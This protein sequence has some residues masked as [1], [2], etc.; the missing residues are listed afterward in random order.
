MV[1]GA[2]SGVGRAIATRFMT[3]GVS[4]CLVGRRSQDLDMTAK[5]GEAARAG[6]GFVF[7]AD[8]SRDV[9]LESLTSAFSQQLG[10]LD[11]LVHSAGVIA[12]GVTESQAVEDFDRQYA[13]N[14]RGPY[15]LTQLMLPWL[16]RQGG[17]V[18][19]INSTQGQRAVAGFGQ[20]AA[21][22]HA[23]RAVAD[24]VREEVNGQR[25][26][27]LS[28]FL[29]RTATPMQER[30]H[31]LNGTTYRPEYLIQPEDVADVVVHT[32]GLPRTAE[33]TDI[34]IRPLAKPEP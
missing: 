11:V 29:G 22:K 28:V 3:L 32:I 2:G 34:V 10:R 5:Q 31:R 16:K 7:E 6:R 25:V 27:V 14:V 8:I 15:R 12:P 26:R 17:D 21:T 23:L 4:V 20:Y 18:V 30:L 33:V 24:S 19:F 9:D 1:T 13:T